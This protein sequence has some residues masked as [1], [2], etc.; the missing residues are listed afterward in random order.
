PD[1]ANY[2]RDGYDFDARY[3]EGL[4]AYRDKEL[5]DLLD[6]NAPVLSKTLKNIGNYRK[7]GKKGFDSIITRLQ[8][9]CYVVTS[10]FVYARDKYGNPYGWGIAEYSTP[11]KLF[12]EEFCDSVY[13]RE[14]EESYQR[15]L[16]HLRRLL[17]E[18]DEKLIKKI[19][20]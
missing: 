18:A 15:L 11:E 3:D 14:P 20:K 19:L 13:E 12:G 5:F 8:A 2:R 7:D 1:L 17:P 9:Q 10:D 16:E 4:A 6:A